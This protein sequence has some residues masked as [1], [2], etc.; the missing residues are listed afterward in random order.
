MRK[1]SSNTSTGGEDGEEVNGAP[2][3]SFTQPAHWESTCLYC[4]PPPKNARLFQ[5]TRFIPSERSRYEESGIQSSGRVSMSAECSR[6]EL[7]A[8]KALI[9]KKKKN[10]DAQGV[11]SRHALFRSLRF[12]QIQSMRPK[13]PHRARSWRLSI[14]RRV[15][16]W[17]VLSSNSQRRQQQLTWSIREKE[18]SLGEKK[19]R[20]RDTYC[21]LPLRTPPLSVTCGESIWI[22][23]CPNSGTGATFES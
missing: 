9:K 5:K 2:A 10:E 22:T 18:E 15:Q 19:T 13:D 21:L 16:T 14:T 23:E 3:R 12:L 8:V 11:R 7:V 20:Q 17:R 1:G 6:F 4:R